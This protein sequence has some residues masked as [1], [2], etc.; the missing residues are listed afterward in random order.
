MYKLVIFILSFFASI[1]LYATG[2]KRESTEIETAHYQGFNTKKLKKESKEDIEKRCLLSSGELTAQMDDIKEKISAFGNRSREYSLLEELEG[3]IKSHK[4][5]T[6]NQW[7]AD[8]FSYLPSK[9]EINEALDRWPKFLQEDAKKIQNSYPNLTTTGGL[10]VDFNEKN[11]ASKNYS[12]HPSNQIGYMALFK[13][14]KD[15]FFLCHKDQNTN[16]K[17]EIAHTMIA[18]A[19]ENAKN[20]DSNGEIHKALNPEL[21]RIPSAADIGSTALACAVLPYKWDQHKADLQNE[22]TRRVFNTNKTLQTNFLIQKY[23]EW[24]KS[25]QTVAQEATEKFL[26]GSNALFNFIHS[27]VKALRKRKSTFSWYSDNEKYA[28]EHGEYFDNHT[29]FLNGGFNFS[30]E[31]NPFTESQLNAFYT[32]DKNQHLLLGT[33]EYE[34]FLQKQKIKDKWNKLT[35]RIINQKRDERLARAKAIKQGFTNDGI[36]FGKLYYETRREQKNQFIQNIKEVEAITGLTIDFEVTPQH[37]NAI[38]EEY[39]N[40][41]LEDKR[42]WRM[43]RDYIKS[44]IIPEIIKDLSL[45]DEALSY[46]DF[47]EKATAFITCKCSECTICISSRYDC[48][49]INGLSARLAK[50]ES[51]YKRISQIKSITSTLNKKHLGEDESSI[52]TKRLSIL[53]DK[54]L[55]KAAIKN[56]RRNTNSD[57]KPRG[58]KEIKI[59]KHIKNADGFTCKENDCEKKFRDIRSLKQ[60]EIDKHKLK[61]KSHGSTTFKAL[62]CKNLYHDIASLQDHLKLLG[63]GNKGKL[64]LSNSDKNR[65][66]YNMNLCFACRTIFGQHRE[67]KKHIN[68]THQAD[69]D[70]IIRGIKNMSFDDSQA[71]ECCTDTVDI[72]QTEERSRINEIRQGF[73]D[74]AR[75]HEE[76]FNSLR[77]NPTKVK[78]TENYWPTKKEIQKIW[79][80]ARSEAENKTTQQNKEEQ[81][82]KDSSSVD[83]QSI[84]PRDM[85]YHPTTHISPEDMIDPFRSDAD[86]SDANMSKSDEL[87]REFY[88]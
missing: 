76:I 71:M 24:I 83:A 86:M 46:E 72:A 82:I 53:T 66:I 2:G 40:L 10:K 18:I 68:D 36:N 84:Y 74:L 73:A 8:R 79:S 61:I 63:S 13:L 52:S 17:K 49:C 11:K 22:A 47:Q 29:G 75:T 80:K 31:V 41:S 57:T 12:W 69:Q 21:K 62:Q 1:N 70:K 34:A 45:S 23:P 35:T 30:N 42:F 50:N 15:M 27:I 78:K 5:N 87:N 37:L 4:K 85:H 58:N 44:T 60:H 39:E 25:R 65:S 20:E 9:P 7:I 51:F 54:G 28:I 32:N 67:L 3:L 77:I 38:L 33:K 55:T 43:K 59:R 88:Q 56:I 19:Q 81:T 14:L 26:E 48:H 64:P 16:G 6:L